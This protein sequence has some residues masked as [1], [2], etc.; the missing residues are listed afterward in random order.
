MLE[1]MSEKNLSDLGAEMR[2]FRPG[3]SYYAFTLR[4]NRRNRLERG[5][6][7]QFVGWSPRNKHWEMRQASLVNPVEHARIW[8]ELGQGWVSVHAEQHLAVF[9]WLGGNA[10]VEHEFA[11]SHLP[12]WL[13]PV[14]V[15]HD[16]DVSMGGYGFLST[17]HLD[18]KAAEAGLARGKRRMRVL[19]RDGYRCVVCGRRPKDHLD[20][21]LDVHHL[22]PRRMGGPT[23]EENLVTLC[24][25]CHDGLA[26]DY[27]PMLRE[28]A[29]LPGPI[30]PLDATGD[31]F[32]E[33]V[34][35]YRVL[36]AQMLTDD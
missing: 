14:E 13:E 30:D 27:Q 10:F 20:L 4:A 5:C 24:G 28:L 6:F 29:G 26:P 33:D 34:A 17:R 18:D 15:V 12:N 22:I 35:R 31:E 19:E 8:D 1:A 9:M 32:V 25:T 16:G 3:C 36:V 2:S 23:A 11:A 7:N 21:E